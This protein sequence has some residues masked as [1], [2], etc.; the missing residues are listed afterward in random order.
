MVADYTFCAYTADRYD[1][2]Q[3]ALG[4]MELYYEPLSIAVREEALWI[5]ALD[6]FMRTLVASGELK[7][8]QEKWFKNRTWIKQLP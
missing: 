8:L 2:K 5:N 4:E 1:D 7:D 6:N 3:L